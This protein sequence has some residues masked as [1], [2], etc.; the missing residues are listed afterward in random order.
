MKKRI[1][2]LLL[3]VVL[4]CAPLA[5]CSSDPSDGFY[6]YDSFLKYISLPNP[7]EVISIEET[8]IE[9]A[10]M[11]AFFALFSDSSDYKEEEASETDVI[12]TGDKVT[13]S[14][15]GTMNGVKVDSATATNQSLTIG[16]NSYIDGFED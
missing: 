8:E 1:L 11:N 10:I 6:E 2:A 16:S 4:G 9:D 14:Y 13:I 12:Q 7:D 15:V 5:A 3:A